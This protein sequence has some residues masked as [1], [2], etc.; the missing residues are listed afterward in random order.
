MARRLPHVSP[1]QLKVLRLVFAVL[2]AISPALAARIAF[3][4]FL[5]PL[6]RKLHPG[7]ASDMA[8]ATRHLLHCASGDAIHVYEWGAGPR[9][10]V[11][12][13]GWGSHAPRCV[14]LAGAL[15]AAG[16]R[17]LA[18][19]APGHGLS[20]GRTSSLPQFMQALDIVTQ[21]MGPA[22]AVL[23]HSL[24]A[25]AV[26]M[27]TGAGPAKGSLRK[28]ALLSMPSGAPYLVESFQQMF[29]IRAAAR[30]RMQVLFRTRF[31]AS[32]D[33]FCALPAA[34]NITLPI[35]L[36]HDRGDDIVPV[37]HSELLLHQLQDAQLHVTQGMGHGGP[38]RNAEAIAVI[39]D[40]LEKD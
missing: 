27:W 37:E 40:F 21:Q 28:V 11:I 32:A 20:P 19:D 1:L 14:P 36:M 26:A 4:L 39:R 25:L 23:G 35:L 12:L 18:I 24:G 10:V 2:Q 34:A 3:R 16:W 31:Q 38:I 17:V 9:T 29:G 7:D 22:H 5:T 13:H 6:R 15:A 30:Q 33:G 8:T